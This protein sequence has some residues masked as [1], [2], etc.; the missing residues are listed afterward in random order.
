MG[1]FSRGLC[2]SPFLIPAR[3]W[4]SEQEHSP[5]SLPS[6]RQTLL[7]DL[8]TLLHEPGFGLRIF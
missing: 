8:C 7:I 2:L 1:V 4:I 6:P 3:L 5:L